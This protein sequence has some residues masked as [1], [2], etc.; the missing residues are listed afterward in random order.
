[1]PKNLELNIRVILLGRSGE[2]QHHTFIRMHKFLNLLLGK[3]ALGNL[4]L[5]WQ[6][7]KTGAGAG[8]VTRECESSSVV[9]NNRELT[10]IDTPGCF[11]TKLSNEDIAKAL[12]DSY[13]EAAPGPHAFL[14]VTTGRH[15]VEAEETL[16]LLVQLFGE[17]VVDYCIV[18]IT[19]EDDLKYDNTTLEEY[20]GNSTSQLR[21]FVNKCSGRCI[22]V[23]SKTKDSNERKEKLTE[24]LECIDNISRSKQTSYYTHELFE[25]A[26]QDEIE[27]RQNEE[28]RVRYELGEKEICIQV[29]IDIKSS[30]DRF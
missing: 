19:H 5:G 24:L 18:M 10:T 7:F 27:R 14:I 6:K 4:I 23:N 11:D 15:T 22:A 20:L 25:K 3:S 16:I 26:A 9:F 12:T 21:S 17:S 29:S 1:M 30:N 2:G 8:S 13:Y 28:Q